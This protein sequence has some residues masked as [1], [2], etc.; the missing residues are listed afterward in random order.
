MNSKRFTLFS[1]FLFLLKFVACLR[2][3][4]NESNNLQIWWKRSDIHG[5]NY[6]KRRVYNEFKESIAD[7]MYRMALMALIADDLPGINRERC[8]KIALVHDIAEAIVGD[9]T[10]SDGVPKVEKSRLEQAALNEMCEVLG[11]GKRAEEIKELWREYE[12]NASLEANLVK[13]FDKIEMILQ[14]LEYETGTFRSRSY[15]C[16]Q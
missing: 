12:D 5:W 8:I 1:I 14:A 6:R 4:S 9:I 10:P 13:D 2:E 11:G 7:H 16:L 15:Y 3:E